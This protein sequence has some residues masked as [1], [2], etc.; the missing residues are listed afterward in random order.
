MRTQNVTTIPTLPYPMTTVYYFPSVM[1]YISDIYIYI[2]IYIYI[3][4]LGPV[5]IYIYIYIYIYTFIYII[6]FEHVFSSA[7]HIF[8]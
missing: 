6:Y 3:L 2:Y 5:Y 4:Q 8:E 1:C 7:V